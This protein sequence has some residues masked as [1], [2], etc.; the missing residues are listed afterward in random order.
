MLPWDVLCLQETFT[1]TE[2]IQ[3][4]ENLKHVVYT[5][6]EKASGLRVP[7][8]LVH[9]RW[10]RSSSYLGSGRRW[11]AVKV[12]DI[13]FLSIHLPHDRS[14]GPSMQDVLFEINEFMQELKM[15]NIF[16][17]LDANTRMHG[18]TDNFCFGDSI[19]VAKE[20]ADRQQT[21]YDFFLRWGMRAV[22]TWLDT[23]DGCE[24]AWKTRFSWSE[25]QAPD[26]VAATATG[27]SQI[28]FVGTTNSI[29]VEEVK[30]VQDMAF[31]T[32]HF[33]IAVSIQVEREKRD[34]RPEPSKADKNK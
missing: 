7:A 2:G 6:A 25:I 12:K 3:L 26:F 4:D 27:G 9:A 28:D 30:I 5:P 23:E 16:V 8:I 15:E 21:L 20:D 19:P 1:R 32:D 18:C 17:G 24:Q 22:N 11:V 13:A 31:N 14:P 33:P 29:L 34:R 10:A